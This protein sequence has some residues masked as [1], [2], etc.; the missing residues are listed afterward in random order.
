[1]VL[2]AAGTVEEYEAI[3]DTVKASLLTLTLT[4]TLT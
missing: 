4:L 3:A 1:M 2:K